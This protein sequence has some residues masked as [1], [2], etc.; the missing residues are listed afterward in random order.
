[1]VWEKL[2]D[3]DSGVGDI[4]LPSGTFT[5]KQYLI[6]IMRIVKGTSL[7]SG[8]GSNVFQFNGVTSASYAWRYNDDGGADSTSTNQGEVRIGDDAGNTCLVRGWIMNIAANEKIGMGTSTI[9]S[10]GVGAGNAVQRAN[11]YFKWA[12]TSNQI[13]SIRYFNDTNATIGT[14]TNLSVWG[15]D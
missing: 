11:A 10:N 1:M 13:T 4:S 3:V 9:A 8:I 6:F 5:A 2:V 14:G 7:G 15:S 12:D